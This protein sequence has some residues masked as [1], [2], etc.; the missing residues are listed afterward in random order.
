MSM[1]PEQAK[2]FICP[3]LGPEELN[4]PFGFGMSVTH[5]KQRPCL[6]T[7]C[8]WW[9]LDPLGIDGEGT[10]AVVGLTALASAINKSVREP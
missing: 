8:M 4:E 5:T 10:C 1:T 3:L 7:E 6:G 9:I 2:D